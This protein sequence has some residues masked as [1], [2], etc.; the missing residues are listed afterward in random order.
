MLPAAA[1]Q[2]ASPRLGQPLRFGALA[3][4]DWL[5]HGVTTRDGPG[6]AG[7][8]SF[9]RG[10]DAATVLAARARWSDRTGVAARDLVLARQVHGTA[11][12]RVEPVRRGRGALAMETLPEADALATNAPGVPLLAVFADCVPIVV[13][14]PARRAVA[15]A[16]AGWR[17]T[18]AGMAEAVVAAMTD[19]Y[20]SRPADLL[21]GIGPSI[22]PCCY[23]VGMEVATVAAARYGDGVLRPGP[24]AHNPTL[25]LWAANR[26]ALLRAG[27]AA[28]H[29]EVAGVC[30]RCRNDL[31]FSHRAEGP[32]R[33]LFGAIIALV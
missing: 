24:A 28:A 14:D 20:G 18:V 11:V 12:E 1:E 16:H 27:L 3:T 29:V 32:T 31:F 19:W 7:N 33:G 30:T 2:S 22:G 26:L 21:A 5:R 23:A 13:V 17:G 6:L 9:A 15:V 4:L 10:P 8:L 25:D